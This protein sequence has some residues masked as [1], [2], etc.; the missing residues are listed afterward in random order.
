MDKLD[1]QDLIL[2]PG[3]AV[4]K[5]IESK[6]LEDDRAWALRQFQKGEPRFFVEHIRRGALLVAQNPKSLLIFSGGRTHQGIYRSEAESCFLVATHY[7]WGIKDQRSRESVKSRS[8]LEA[9][10]RDSFENFLFG[11]CRF[12]QVT[13][14]YPRK[15]VV[16]SW[17]FESFRFNL[18][19]MAVRFPKPR[20]RFVGVNNPA[21]ASRALQGERKTMMLFL[22]D[23][24]GAG[25]MLNKKRVERN[26]FNEQHTYRNCPG[27]EKYFNFIENSENGQDFYRFKLPWQ[28]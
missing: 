12:Q 28:D 6:H 27:L 19:R 21:D 8:R 17:A 11:I 23:F 1:L 4:L 20:Y 18:H 16:V 25:E 2:V 13:K 9:F 15:V 24:Y 3:H 14:R 26:P 5:D 7:N 22:E 10:A